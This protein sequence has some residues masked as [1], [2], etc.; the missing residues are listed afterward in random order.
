[1]SQRR[2]W[3]VGHLTPA[4]LLDLDLRLVHLS[5]IDT[6]M[7]R[8]WNNIVIVAFYDAIVRG[9]STEHRSREGL[10]DMVPT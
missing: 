2:G 6:M 1:M 7:A 8:E 5:D 10:L 3:L 4:L 9:N